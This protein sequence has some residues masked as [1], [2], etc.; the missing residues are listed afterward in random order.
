MHP[1]CGVQ[2]SVCR[3]EVWKNDTQSPFCPFTRII[4][5]FELQWVRGE[6]L[7]AF[8]GSCVKL[9]TNAQNLPHGSQTPPTMFSSSTLQEQQ[10]SQEQTLILLLISQS[11]KDAIVLLKNHFR[12]IV[13]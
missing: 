3:F 12:C 1:V 7:N 5:A 10:H 2:I 4:C 11:L 9:D 13:L 6:G 8:L